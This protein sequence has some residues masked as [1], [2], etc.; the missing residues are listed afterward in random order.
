MTTETIHISQLRSLKLFNML[1]DVDLEYI[2]KCSTVI[3]VSK[4]TQLF[5]QLEKI[6]N[7]YFVLEGQ[8]RI[9]RIDHK[10][11]FQIINI[12]G[13]G[14]MFPHTGYYRPQNYPAYAETMLCSKL[15]MISLEEFR[16]ILAKYPSIHIML[17][18]ILEERLSDLHSNLEEKMLHQFSDQISHLL[19]RLCETF[20]KAQ[21]HEWTLITIFL[22][23]RDVANLIGSTRETINRHLNALRRKRIIDYT[24]DGY[25]LVNREKLQ[26]ILEYGD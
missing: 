20:G 12:A 7:I 25:L 8:V 17:Y 5:S 6:N 1:K 26:N 23:N 16:S 9:Y 24:E 11:N 14:D 2:L 18:N 22:T 4:K 10:G 3:C 13:N 21:T 19:I 15:L